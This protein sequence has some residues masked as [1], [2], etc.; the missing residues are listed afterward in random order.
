M[1]QT[2]LLP[3]ALLYTKSRESIDGST[4]FQKLVFLLQ[5]ET[6]APESFEYQSAQY[7]PFSVSLARG[8][9]TLESNGYIKRTVETNA[10]G[11][12]RDIYRIT[13]EGIQLAQAMVKK[14]QYQPLFDYSEEIKS[15][16]NSRSL[17]ELLQY[18][19]RKYPDFA[20]DTE[21][22]TGRLFDPE[23]KSE[24]LEPDVDE[25]EINV[26]AY[27]E[28]P[29]IFENK[30]GS[31]TARDEHYELTALAETHEKA[32]KELARVIAASRDEGGEE[33]SEEFLEGLGVDPEVAND[34][35]V[36]DVPEFMI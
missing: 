32:K 28:E 7:G 34:D 30:D 14:D 31:W 8:L 17:D 29:L 9:E 4:R 25:A 27:L 19:Y 5:K 21:L 24:F 1:T 6:E 20:E 33:V 23:A 35:S 18:V 10:V 26:S 36:D 15:R 22:D 2:K 16:Y 11:N 3:I 12:E 13:T